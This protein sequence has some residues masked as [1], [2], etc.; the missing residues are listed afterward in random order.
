MENIQS[1]AADP[2]RLWNI[3]QVADYALVTVKTVRRWHKNGAGPPR[4]RIGGSI[5]YRVGDVLDWAKTKTDAA[6]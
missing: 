1:L 2:D 3:E 6:A 5:R 4:V